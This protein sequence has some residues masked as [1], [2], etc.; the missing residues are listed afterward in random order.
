MKTVTL[1]I[2]TALLHVTSLTAQVV[3]QPVVT[4]PTVT[5]SVPKFET[6]HSVL[7]QRVHTLKLDGTDYMVEILK[8]GETRTKVKRLSDQKEFEIP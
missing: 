5:D 1:L 2:T 4:Q 6:P 7:M 8:V 3:E